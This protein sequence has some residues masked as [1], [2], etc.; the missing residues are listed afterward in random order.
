MFPI[1]RHDPKT[2]S[3]M[4]NVNPS[5]LLYTWTP[6]SRSINERYMYNVYSFASKHTWKLVILL[7]PPF[8]LED[9]GFEEK[10]L[11]DGE[12]LLDA[13]S[14]KATFQLSFHITFF[15]SITMLYGI[16]NISQTVPIKFSVGNIWEY[17]V[18]C[19]ES[20]RTLLW[21]WRMSC[22]LRARL[23]HNFSL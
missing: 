3:W 9:W 11:V 22:N 6:K 2:R 15:R 13:H 23:F 10:S 8:T 20:H 18:E 19:C 12:P 21:I 1:T 4:R 17:Y 7:R 16:D 14:F 5:S